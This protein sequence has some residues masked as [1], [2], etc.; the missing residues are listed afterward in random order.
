MPAMA[1]P[2]GTAPEEAESVALP[3]A[4]VLAS[5]WRRLLTRVCPASLA[6]LTHCLEANGALDGFLD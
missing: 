5:S 3:V 1:L 4:P 2:W 6:T